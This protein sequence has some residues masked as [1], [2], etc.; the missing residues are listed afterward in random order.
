MPGNAYVSL[1]K[2]LQSANFTEWFN[3]IRIMLH[4]V[5]YVC[6]YIRSCPIVCL[7]SSVVLYYG[8]L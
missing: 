8:S 2:L 7:V 4:V 3:S 5:K 6:M 1:L